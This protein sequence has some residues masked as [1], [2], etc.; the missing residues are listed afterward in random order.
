[1]LSGR[2]SN[3]DEDEVEDELE[4]MEAA[5]RQKTQKLPDAPDIMKEEMPDAP[6]DVPVQE[7][8]AERAKRRRRERAEEQAAQPMAA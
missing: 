5:Q 3:N 1:M 2:M 7:T 8:P 6:R 4:D